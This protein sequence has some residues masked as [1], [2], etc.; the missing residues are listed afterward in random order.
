MNQFLRGM[1]RAVAE[2]FHLPGPFLEIGSMQVEGASDDINLRSLFP[3]SDYTGVDFRAGPGVDC[4]ASVENLPQ[5]S[6]SVGTV[7]ALSTFEHVQRFWL[8]FDEV[9]RVLRPDGV[10]VVASPFYFHVH[11][12]PSDYWRFTPEAFDFMLRDHYSR[13]L[14]GWH[15][16]ARRMANV[17]SVAFR[18]KARMPTGSDIDTYRRKMAEHAREPLPWLKRLKYQA[19]RVL[20]GKRPFAPHL[21]R[22]KWGMEMRGGPG[23]AKAA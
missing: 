12:Y 17:W 19:G 15:G 21:D 14:L 5:T 1:M 9:R 8:G 6:G 2:S 13:R 23:D 20:C 22:E 11:G 10:F 3:G 16:P 18:E 4:V 7:L